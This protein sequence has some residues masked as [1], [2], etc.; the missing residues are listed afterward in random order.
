ML[1]N[2]TKPVIFRG[3]PLSNFARVELMLPDPDG[4]IRSC[5]SVEHYFQ[6]A[7]A[8]DPAGHQAVR[9]AATPREA[10]RRGRQVKMQGDW[11]D[12]KRGV[13]LAALRVKF[14]REPFRSALLATRT[15]V[16]IEESR[17]D[18]EWG[19]SRT[20]DGW[21]GENALGQLLMLVR[22]ELGVRSDD[23]PQEEQLALPV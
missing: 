6:A 10:K 7:K 18:T 14:A 15:R 8:V 2:A 23:G 4:T 5:R 13:M 19:A 20:P 21:A 16:I 17:H 11:D 9:E 22:D 12:I 1:D 3:G